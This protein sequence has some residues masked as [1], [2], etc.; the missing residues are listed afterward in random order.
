MLVRD[1]VMASNKNADKLDTISWGRKITSRKVRHFVT[2][3][4]LSFECALV[5]LCGLR[6]LPGI[7]SDRTHWRK[8]HGIDV[9][10]RALAQSDRWW[11]FIVLRVDS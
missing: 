1:G 3:H 2:L 5:S 7:A 10:C 8:N 9:C 4:P 11:Y 6:L